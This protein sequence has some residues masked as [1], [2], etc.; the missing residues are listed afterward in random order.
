MSH[1]LGLKVFFFQPPIKLN[2]WSV[3]KILKGFRAV[4]GVRVIPKINI[5]ILGGSIDRLYFL[6]VGSFLGCFFFFFNKLDCFLLEL[7]SVVQPT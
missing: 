3:C 2:R 5:N 7:F 4:M 1:N 6:R